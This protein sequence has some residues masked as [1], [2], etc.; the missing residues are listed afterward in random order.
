MILVKI[1]LIAALSVRFCWVAGL[2]GSATE[3]AR[4]ILLELSPGDNAHL[5]RQAVAF[6]G[7]VGQRAF[8]CHEAR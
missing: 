1:T 2:R 3:N 7:G 8:R 6:G 4:N 5:M